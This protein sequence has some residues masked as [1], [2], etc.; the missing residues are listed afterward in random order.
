MP[1]DDPKNLISRYIEDVWNKADLE[2]LES[3]T[4]STF[5]YHLGGQ[6]PRDISA[7]RQFLQAVHMAFPDW[8]VEIQDIIAEDHIVAVR[9]SGKATHKGAFHG[10]PPTGKQIFVCGINIY[11]TDNG[12]ISKEWE[13]MDSLGMLQQLGIL[14]VQQS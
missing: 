13:Q 6:P 7:M 2:A 8:R 4:N 9:W 14:P 12:K 11:R 5:T 3:L 10:I 1:T